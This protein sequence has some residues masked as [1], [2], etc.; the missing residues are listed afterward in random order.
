M[1]PLRGAQSEFSNANVSLHPSLSLT[2]QSYSVL[3]PFAVCVDQTNHVCTLVEDKVL[4]SIGT[5]MKRTTNSRGLPNAPAALDNV[6]SPQIVQELITPSN[7]SHPSDHHAVGSQCYIT[8]V[9]G[10]SS[11]A[12]Y[13][14]STSTWQWQKPRGRIGS[15]STSRR[16]F[17][18][19][20]VSRFTGTASLLLA[21]CQT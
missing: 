13:S 19:Q 12:G 18:P 11:E 9:R 8:S 10:G 3:L 20:F 17:N 5:E 16:G 14:T 7:A 21:P 6:D 2:F 4:C 15:G 1:Q